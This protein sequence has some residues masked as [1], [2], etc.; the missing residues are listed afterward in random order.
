VWF[1]FLG[2]RSHARVEPLLSDKAT[3]AMNSQEEVCVVRSG[4]C[5]DEEVCVTE[6]KRKME[7]IFSLLFYLFTLKTYN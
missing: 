3:H 4:G 2:V 1:T 6:N 7:L 5:G